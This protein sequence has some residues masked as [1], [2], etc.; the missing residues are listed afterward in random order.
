[1]KQTVP[2]WAIGAILTF[3]VG[4]STPRAV[5]SP[6][7]SGEKLNL[8]PLSISVVPTKSYDEPS[9][10]G[11]SMAKNSPGSFYVILRNTSR[12]PQLVFESWNSWGYQAV[13]FQVQTATGDKFV[14]SKGPPHLRANLPSTFLIP[15]G[16]HMVYPITLD[17]E[18]DAVPSLPT[19]DQTP[20]PITI[21][22]IYE[23]RPTPEA[24]EKKVWTGR[25]ES[26]SYHFNLMHW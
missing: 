10:R 7:A 1:M 21:K 13:S 6:A 11:I 15:P 5:Q 25:V 2:G 16:E 18:W 26:I 20:L 17:D 24:A 23:I 12:E 4:C 8:S 19:A 22:A 9:G 14:I 3:V